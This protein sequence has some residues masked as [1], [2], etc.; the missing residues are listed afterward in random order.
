M[1]PLALART[2]ARRQTGAL[3][4]VAIILAAGIG[5]ALASLEV[6]RRT[7]DAYPA[8]LRKGD[9]GDLVVN[10]VLATRRAEEIIRT[11]PGVE[12]VVSD[13]L[14]TAT[15]DAGRP[16]S[17][18]EIDSDLTQVRFSADGR[19]VAQ[20]RPVVRSG[21]MIRGGAEDRR[22]SAGYEV[23]WGR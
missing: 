4:A 8:Y 3:V 13:S 23:A 18:T 19:Y 17:R 20:D 14:L 10:P 21:H 6:A 12:R 5:A 7:E 1:I 15:P 11:V 22:S 16:R 2:T 9:V